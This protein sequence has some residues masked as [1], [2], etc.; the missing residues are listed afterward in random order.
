MTSESLITDVPLNVVCTLLMIL[1][2]SSTCWQIIVKETYLAST[3][4]SLYESSR[5][6]F[7]LR[8]KPHHTHVRDPL[9]KSDTVVTE[10]NH[11]HQLYMM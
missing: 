5:C 10:L 6:Y 3:S 8:C 1:H 4:L 7:V 9:T 2:L 11:L